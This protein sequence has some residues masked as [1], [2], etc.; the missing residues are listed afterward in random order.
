MPGSS[1]LD[2]HHRGQSA[3]NDSYDHEAES[4]FAHDGVRVVRGIAVE[5]PA[6]D[7]AE[8]LAEAVNVKVRR[9]KSGKPTINDAL[10]ANLMKA[11]HRLDRNIQ[12]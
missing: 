4:D 5:E 12:R 11:A 2:D 6:N 8:R 3:G 10:F 7:I 1:S 9:T